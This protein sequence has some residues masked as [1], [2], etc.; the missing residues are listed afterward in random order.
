MADVD[1]YSQALQYLETHHI[2]PLFH[3]LTAN[4]VY[5]QPIDPVDYI[6]RYTRVIQ[7]H[8]K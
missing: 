1:P 8:K 4:I 7:I 6:I 5:H 2:L 3:N